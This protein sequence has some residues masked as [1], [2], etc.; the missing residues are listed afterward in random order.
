MLAAVSMLH[1]TG[2]GTND[3]KVPSEY[4]FSFYRSAVPC[5]RTERLTCTAREHIKMKEHGLN[6]NAAQVACLRLSGVPTAPTVVVGNIHVLFNQKRGDVKLGQVSVCSS[7]F[8]TQ[9]HAETCT[10]YCCRR[11]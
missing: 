8:V 11:Y 2:R 3:F 6:D 1:T 5:R 7:E 4:C 9:K 10:S